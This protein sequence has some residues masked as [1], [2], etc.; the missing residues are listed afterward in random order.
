MSIPISSFSGS[1]QNVVLKAPHQKYDPTDPEHQ[2]RLTRGPHHPLH[3][4]TS[5]S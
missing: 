1:T 3:G 5:W 4:H 2:R